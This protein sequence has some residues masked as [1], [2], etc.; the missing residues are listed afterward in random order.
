VLYADKVFLLE[1][2]RIVESGRHHELV[3]LKGLYCAMWRQQIGKGAILQTLYA[4][5]SPTLINSRRSAP[6]QMSILKF[7]EWLNET[8]LSIYLREGDWSFPILATIHILGI[9]FS[10]G[11]ITWLDLR[12]LGLVM[13]NEPTSA[14]V[15]GIEPMAILG[16]SLMF[17]SGMLLFISEPMKC[18]NAV[19]FR[20]KVVM[21]ILAGFNVLYFHK[22]VMPDM[23][24]W[25]RIIPWRAKMVG[26]FSLVLWFGIIVAGRWTAYF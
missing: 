20:L 9:G 4:T 22:K 7:A 19:S 11:M 25:D 12:L 1:R 18:Y 6:R 10:V 15:K 17:I 2:G 23:Y 3:E 8:P 14:V 24:Q 13:K 26:L 21:L 5:K 16:F